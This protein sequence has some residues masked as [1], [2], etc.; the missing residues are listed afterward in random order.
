MAMLNGQYSDHATR[1]LVE[2]VLRAIARLRVTWMTDHDR[3][4]TLLRNYCDRGMYFVLFM[5]TETRLLSL[6]SDHILRKYGGFLYVATLFMAG[7]A[8]HFAVLS[9]D[10]FPLL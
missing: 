2:M 9:N 1:Y 3:S 10:C 8:S 6:P 5:P 4:S 7:W